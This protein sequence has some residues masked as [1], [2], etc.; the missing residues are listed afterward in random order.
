[1][2]PRMEFERQM[3][4]HCA[5]VVRDMISALSPPNSGKRNYILSIV[6][7]MGVDMGRRGFNCLTDR[8]QTDPWE[9]FSSITNVVKKMYR[10]VYSW[11]M[12]VLSSILFRGWWSLLFVRSPRKMFNTTVKQGNGNGSSSSSFTEGDATAAFGSMTGGGHPPY[13]EESAKSIMINFVAEHNDWTYLFEGCGQ[14][15]NVRNVATYI[16]GSEFSCQKINVNDTSIIEKR[17]AVVF[18][19]PDRG[20]VATCMCALRVHMTQT[21]RL[22]ASGKE[23]QQYTIT[24]VEHV[25]EKKL[26]KVT[27]LLHLI[28]FSAFCESVDNVITDSENITRFITCDDKNVIMSW[29]PSCRA[30]WN[31]MQPVKGC[32][33]SEV[34]QALQ[35]QGLS[36]ATPDAR[37]KCAME[38]TLVMF[39]VI[40]PN[41]TNSRRFRMKGTLFGVTVFSRTTEMLFYD[42]LDYLSKSLY[43]LNIHDEIQDVSEWFKYNGFLVWPEGYSEPAAS[44]ESS[45]KKIVHDG[46]PVKI[47]AMASCNNETM[48]V[49]P[50]IS[51]PKALMQAWTDF[52]SDCQA[53]HVMHKRRL[54]AILTREDGAPTV[55]T[56]T[57]RVQEEDTVIQRPNLKYAT[58]VENYERMKKIYNS[59]SKKKKKDDDG[60]GESKVEEDEDHP[61]LKPPKKMIESIV[62]QK[63][64]ERQ[65]MTNTSRDMSTLFLREED[66]QQLLNCL[67]TFRTQKGLMRHLGLPNKLGVMLHGLPG[68]GKSSTVSAIASYLEKDVYYLQLDKVKD[69]NELRLLFEFVFQK[70][71]EGGII[72]MEDVDATTDVVKKRQENPPSNRD[73]EVHCATLAESSIK[74][75]EVR[76]KSR[77]RHETSVSSEDDTIHESSSDDTFFSSEEENDDAAASKRRYGPHDK[78]ARLKKAKKKSRYHGAAKKQK[79]KRNEHKSEDDS[80]S[81]EQSSHKNNDSKVTLEFLLNLLQGSLT[82]DG[83]VFIATT[84][85]IDSLDPAFYRKGRFDVSIEMRP[86]DTYQIA[87]IYNKF[88]SRDPPQ[89]ILLRIPR[90][91]YAPAALISHF[92]Q[93]IVRERSLMQEHATL[94]SS[95][96]SSVYKRDAEILSPFAQNTIM[97]N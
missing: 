3:Q 95:D 91:V 64:V 34:W 81:S 20:F 9:V 47:E 97:E 28:P 40:H 63:H 5:E 96:S 24:R 12:N 48:T 90:D 42:F 19:V 46:F 14:G 62:T 21:R 22:T 53:E 37:K 72:V 57:L 25:P 75:A 45:E 7:L 84:N 60:G 8:I 73:V 23:Y 76:A 87:R 16:R 68:T 1:M 66:E 52:M 78:N 94:S 77:R 74:N 2:D 13:E 50:A 80:S 43:R 15:K 44:A 39:A 36:F 89:D 92:S 11:I 56:Y 55:K 6:A 93:F 32:F 18:R 29:S 54:T 86:A 70:C 61:F 31:Y 10:A 41:A 82:L 38:L 30:R 79:K 85:H 65:F 67:Y 59:Y 71:P 69:N 26:S 88:F 35:S 58:Q 49:F 4:M 33:F 27:S 83:T 51:T 17:D